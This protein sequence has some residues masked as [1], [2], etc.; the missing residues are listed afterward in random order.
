MWRAM[1][2]LPCALLAGLAFAGGCKSSERPAVRSRPIVLGPPVIDVRRGTGSFP[3]DGRDI[4]SSGD[5]VASLSAAY[6]QRV[7]RPSVA[8]QPDL[9]D[10]GQADAVPLACAGMPGEAAS[11]AEDAAPQA[12]TADHPRA[13]AYQ[14]VSQW[15]QAEGEFPLLDRLRVDLSESTVHPDFEPRGFESAASDEGVVYVRRLDYVASPL[16]FGGASMDITLEADEAL[17]GLMRDRRGGR[18][19]VLLGAASGEMRFAMTISDMEAMVRAGGSRGPMRVDDVRIE[20]ASS[21]PRSLEAAMWVK[22]RWLMLPMTF[23]VSGAVDIDRW[24]LVH[25]RDLRAVGHDPGGDLAAVFINS[26]LD[27]LRDRVSPMI[28][29][30]DGVTSVTDVRIHADDGVDLV[31]RFGRDPS[32]K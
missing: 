32:A 29:F 20:I 24:H 4:A 15:I 22:A 6:L 14:P 19:L 28:L 11:P 2:I 13:I 21:S 31:V 27:R 1:Y 25:Y 30:A 18:G 9:L 17:L 5:L 8:T 16:R 7:W 12:Q 3:L 23:R 10:P 26:M